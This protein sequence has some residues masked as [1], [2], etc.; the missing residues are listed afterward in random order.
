MP[1]ANH[2][3]PIPPDQK[4]APETFSPPPHTAPAA[5]HPVPGCP[6]VRLWLASARAVS[7][8]HLPHRPA[9]PRP[10]NAHSFR[11]PRGRAADGYPAGNVEASSPGQASPDLDWQSAGRGI[12]IQKVAASVVRPLRAAPACAAE[13]A[14]ASAHRPEPRPAGAVA[15]V[16][17]GPESA[18]AAR[19]APSRG[20]LRQGLP[21]DWKPMRRGEA[22]A[23]QT[24]RP[25][26][27][28]SRHDGKP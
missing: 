17:A 23:V 28:R 4:P 6:D 7:R 27:P 12:E 3:A 22:P 1:R 10:V 9:P 13:V 14:A 25:R 8:P 26:A 5:R 16:Q 21:W 18:A 20:R 19:V 15:P 2:A 24:A 11:K